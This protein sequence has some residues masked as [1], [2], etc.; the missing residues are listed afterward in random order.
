MVA[1]ILSLLILFIVDLKDA[2]VYFMSDDRELTIQNLVYELKDLI[3]W[4]LLGIQLGLN[5]STLDKIEVDVNGKP[6]SVDLAKL[7]LFDRWLKSGELHNW[8]Q[9]IEALKKID[10]IKLANDLNRKYIEPDD[11]SVSQTDITTTHNAKANPVI[12]KLSRFGQFSRSFGEV[13]REFRSI[14][15]EIHSALEDEHVSTTD[16]IR[17]CRDCLDM[18]S[19]QLPLDET[20]TVDSLFDAIKPYYS[21]LDYTLIEEIVLCHLKTHQSITVR[22]NQYKKQLNEF[23]QSTELKELMENIEKAQ[24][25]PVSPAEPNFPGLCVVQLTLVEKW[26]PRSIKNVKSLMKE[27]F[28]GKESILKNLRVVAGSVVVIY[29]APAFEAENLIARVEDSFSLLPNVGICE[30]QVTVAGQFLFQKETGINDKSDFSFEASF[31]RAVENNDIHLTSFLLEL[32]IDP[33]DFVDFLHDPSTERSTHATAFFIASQ[34]GLCEIMDLL[35]SHGANVNKI[36]GDGRTPLMAAS[37]RGHVNAVEKLL[38][39]GAFLEIPDEDGDTALRYAIDGETHQVIEL[40]LRKGANPN[41]VGADR[42]SCLLL[43]CCDNNYNIVSLLLQ[44]GADQSH[45]SSLGKTCLMMASQNGHLETMRILLKEATLKEINQTMEGGWCA[46]SLA[47]D[48]PEAVEL[49]LEYGADPNIT[50]E[51]GWTTLMLACE[52]G[53]SKT[54]TALLNIRHTDVNLMTSS[55]ATAYGI[56]ELKNDKEIKLA[57]KKVGA[58]PKPFVKTMVH[59]FVP[60]KTKYAQMEMR[61]KLPIVKRLWKSASLSIQHAVKL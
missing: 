30:V 21:Y 60:S 24:T 54:V 59:L 40:L 18:S 61:K 25:P 32:N 8:K 4:K 41:V 34:R 57:L 10:E 26:L 46:L 14:V 33:S 49:L 55:G 53:Y 44:H 39:S 15:V 38:N 1:L 36:T 35:L 6:N 51:D 12:V 16:V 28:K 19:T 9:V 43:S 23:L 11:A 31:I 47:Y 42:W 13:E 48:H 56:A 20:K 37:K 3:N 7:E 50:L 52:K 17:T 5:K 2:E 58:K 45:M 22:L 29:T 27:V